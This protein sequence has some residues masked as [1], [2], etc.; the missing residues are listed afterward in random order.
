MEPGFFSE[1]TL[2]ETSLKNNSDFQLKIDE[3]ISESST[4]LTVNFDCGNKDKGLLKIQLKDILKSINLISLKKLKTIVFNE[5]I[6]IG[7][8]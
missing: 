2:A 4:Y 5:P 6:L 3:Y 7:N 1:D 8:E